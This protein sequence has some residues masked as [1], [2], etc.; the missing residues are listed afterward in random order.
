MSQFGGYQE[1]FY[2]QQQGGTPPATSDAPAQ[3]GPAHHTKKRLY[4]QQQY[5]F[6]APAAPAYPGAGSGEASYPGAPGYGS[7]TPAAAGAV[8]TPAAGIPTPG[9]GAAGAAGASPYGQP[10]A[11]PLSAQFGAMNIGGAAPQAPAPYGQPMAGAVGRP[12]L[13]QLYNIDLL[14]SLPPPITDLALPPPPIILPAGSCASQN[15]EANSGPDYIRSTLNVVPTSNSLL[16]KSKLPFALVIRP[17][18]S[19]HNASAPVKVTSDTLICRCRR[20]RSYINPFVSFNE[21]AHRWKCNICGLNNDVPQ[22]FDWDAAR[23]MRTDRYTRNEIN[24]GVVEFIAPPEYM[25][26]PPQPPV[27]VFVLDVSI[28]AVQNG[29]LATA[30]RTIQESLDRLPNK[31]DR[32]KVGFIAVDSSL[33]YFNIPVP[34]S[35]AEPSMLVVS[36]LEDP[37]LPL[38]TGLLVNLTECRSSIELLLSRLGEMF[39]QNLNPNNALGS[40]LKAAHKLIGS[41]GGKIVCLTAS[42]PNVGFAKLE[43]REDRKA[44]GTAKETALLQT[45]S[46]FYKSFAIEC[47]RSQVT[48]DMFLFAQQYQDVASLSNLPRF[49]GG[50]TYFYPGWSASR[51]EDAIKFAHEL[52]EHLSMEISL[53][54]VLRVRASTELRM[55]SFYGNFFNRSSDLCSFPSFP[56]DQSYVVEVAIDDTISKPWV[57]FQAAILHTT[58]EGERRIRVIT[59]ALP[60]SSILQDIYASADQLAITSYFTQKAVEKALSSG[61]QDARDLVQAKLYDILQTYKKDLM[62]TNVG[63]SAPLQF[64]ANLRMLPLLMNA[65]I[66]NVGLRK[67]VQIPSDMRSAALCLLSTLPVKYL[68]KYLHP[69][70]FS[71]Y[72][73]PDEAGLPNEETGEIVLPPKLNLSGERL[74]PHGLYLIDDGQTMFIWVGRDVVPQLSLDAFGVESLS[75][76]PS[77]KT[78]FPESDSPLNERIR[79]IIGKLREKKDA[80][81]WP[82]LFIIKEDGD[83]S[84]RLWATTFLVEDRAD[85]IPSYYQFLTSLR[86]KLS[87]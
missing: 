5:D 13:N 12:A 56:R 86:D 19:L 32:A 31:D 33:H 18:I 42:L 78:E 29:L 14:A 46:S 58:C 70:F 40:A 52:G 62:T 59:L 67:S 57:C 6:S 20:C 73:M 63:A 11:D 21:Q 87:A 26:R 30:A 4:P 9:A 83:P 81:T 65:L 47:N 80:I 66:K 71:L 3:A 17:Y 28:H 68:I 7:G 74:V 37:Y 22:Q 16:K 36:D 54:A 23:N 77:G 49:T 55:S 10:Q 2:Q 35:Q 44:L 64:C 48:V 75:K 41:L 39:A 82:S 38:P 84:L 69:D 8:F 15:P 45:A 60:T 50:Q 76:V 85:D 34:P 79:A 72:D 1:G 51:A 25:V 24:H 27:Y 43:P 53:E 61:L